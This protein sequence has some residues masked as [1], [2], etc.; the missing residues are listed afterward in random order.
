[1]CEVGHAFEE[2]GA[3]NIQ[4]LANRIGLSNRVVHDMT[5]KLVESDMLRRVTTGAGEEE[6]LTL[7][8]PAKKISIADI[9]ELAH[10]VRPTSDHPAWKTL[11]NLK[12]AERAAAE[13]KTL[14]DVLVW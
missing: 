6:S 13:G 1:M 14:A 3:L 2:G 7:A 5:G 8:R 10:H 4:E 11:A 9:L 12:Q